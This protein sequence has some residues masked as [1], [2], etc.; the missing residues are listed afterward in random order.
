MEATVFKNRR[1]G[2]IIIVIALVVIPFLNP[3]NT[4]IVSS[5]DLAPKEV[6]TTERISIL[7]SSEDR[8]KLQIP[9]QSFR[10]KHPDIGFTLAMDSRVFTTRPP[11]ICT[12]DQSSPD[13]VLVNG[14]YIKKSS[15]DKPYIKAFLYETL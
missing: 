6:I 15:S 9:I 14:Y 4:K 12:I 7:T 10:K 5:K 11:D 2:L 1:T 13:Y 8:A 3:R